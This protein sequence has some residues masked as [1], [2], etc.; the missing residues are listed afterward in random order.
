MKTFFIVL[1]PLSMLLSACSDNKS[2]KVADDASLSGMVES[3]A[4]VMQKARDVEG[5]LQDTD[6]KHRMAPGQ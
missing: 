1:L 2:A 6:K 5:L 3:Q 4:K